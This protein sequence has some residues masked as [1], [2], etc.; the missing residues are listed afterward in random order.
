MAGYVLGLRGGPEGTDYGLILSLG[1]RGTGAGWLYWQATRF[2]LSVPL[3][4]A[5]FI[6]Q[7]S[8]MRPLGTAHRYS[9]SRDRSNLHKAPSDLLRCPSQSMRISTTHC[10]QELF[11]DRIWATI[12]P[13]LSSLSEAV[14]LKRCG[15][16]WPQRPSSRPGGTDSVRF[17]APSGLV[18]S[19]S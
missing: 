6:T 9:H 16:A 12:P 13:Y 4:K 8:G 19:P 17:Y 7:R 1:L 5:A 18:F 14:L 10:D 3:H 11:L 15:R 2:G